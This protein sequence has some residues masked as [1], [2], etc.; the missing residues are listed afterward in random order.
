MPPTTPKFC[1][2]A[3]IRSATSLADSCYC[4]VCCCLRASSGASC[5][6][7]LKIRVSNVYVNTAYL[8][9]HHHTLMRL[10]KPERSA[11]SLSCIEPLESLLSA[12]LHTT[13]ASGP[14]LTESLLLGFY[15]SYS[16][17]S[18]VRLCSPGSRRHVGI[19]HNPR[20]QR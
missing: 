18:H 9:T 11:R 4:L 3:H 5:S 8:Q 2:L 19:D 13:K 14:N 7:I 17:C 20:A 1:V 16:G 12:E 15:Q 6:H 10:P